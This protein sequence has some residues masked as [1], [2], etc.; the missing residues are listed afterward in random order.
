[1]TASGVTI[2]FNHMVELNQAG[3][4]STYAALADPSRRAILARLR[5][6]AARVTEIA[7]P[8]D[9]SLNAVSK[10]IR[11]LERAG[12]IRREISGRDHFLTVNVE[13]LIEAS[14]WIEEQKTFWEG[15]LDALESFLQRKKRKAQMHEAPRGRT[16][17]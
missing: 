5:R 8:F 16:K 12:L 9:M 1:M 11:V 14:G 10:H 3:L 13:P 4:N 6:G 2:I 7:E 17:N 15:R